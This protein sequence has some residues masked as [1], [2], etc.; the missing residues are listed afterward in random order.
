YFNK[1][2]S[3]LKKALLHCILINPPVW[4]DSPQKELMDTCLKEFAT[5]KLLIAGSSRLAGIQLAT[6]L[7]SK[8]QRLEQFDLVY[9]IS[10][11][12]EFHYSV[13]EIKT[14]K[15]KRYA[16][17]SNKYLE[18]VNAEKLIR[19][20]Y[21]KVMQICSTKSKLSVNDMKVLREAKTNSLPLLALKS[22]KF[23]HFIYN[24][25]IGKYYAEH[26]YPRVIEY[27][28]KALQSFSKDHPNIAALRFAFTSKKIIA[29]IALEK[30]AKAKAIAKEASQLMPM[31]KFNWHLILIQRIIICFHSGAYQEAYELYKA[32][33]KYQCPYS[34]LA[35][36]WKII[37]GYLYF[38]I[39][40]GR[41]EA[42]GEERF[43]L[44][45]FLNEIPIFSQDKA[46]VNIN[47]IL[48]QILILMQ[49]GHFG[50][51]IDKIEAIQAYA[52]KHTRQP[53]T[54]RA[55]CFIQMIV[56]MEAASFHRASTERKTQKYWQQLEAT[57]IRF[58]Q[59]L[60][61][62]MV[63]YAALWA[64][65]LDMLDHKFR[66]VRAKKKTTIR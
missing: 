3:Q 48:I 9:V 35:E 36:Y 54:A 12:L 66:A 38:F 62:E 47:V 21:G 26:D 33:T 8:A 42:Y 15:A 55:H 23:N 41:I 7:L 58:G 34:L 46:G 37:Q 49:R 5:Y 59:S 53:E 45:K 57:P 10:S 50:R 6:Q 14:G 17:I 61:V 52:R 32:Q 24:I 16:Q 43:N 29:F 19:R 28:D 30:Y 27:C 51:I 4:A 25:I 65:I 2:K 1:L 13:N 56:K 39:Q 22:N 64:I 20:Y 60:A 11:D 44:G 40:A 18:L 63:P 31:G